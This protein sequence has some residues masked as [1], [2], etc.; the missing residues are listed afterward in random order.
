MRTTITSLAAAVTLG[1]SLTACVQQNDDPSAI[2]RVL[3]TA[4]Q[5]KIRLP[6][7]AAGAARAV[8][9][10]ADWYVATRAVTRTLN[11][12]TAMVLILVHTIVLFPPT[13]VEGSTSVWGPH[14]DAQDPAEWRLTATALADGTYDWHLDAHSRITPTDPWETLIDGNAHGDGTGRFS[15]DFDAAERANPIDN[16]GHGVIGVTYDVGR[17][18]LAMD[19]DTVEDTGNG[20]TDVHFEYGY[21]EAADGSGDMVFGTYADTDDAGA[22]PEEALLRSRWTATGPGRSDVRLRSGDLPVEVT[23]SECW[24]G[25][26]RRVYYADSASWLPTEGAAENCAFAS[27]DLPAR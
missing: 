12:G 15:L 27:Q 25:Q 19:V 17:K 14:H 5:V 11:G 22:L 8:G 4:D 16:D 20:P 3:P 6:E 26:F 23:A 24:N 10:V 7:T 18:T 9:D 1:L 2:A 21:Q 13:T